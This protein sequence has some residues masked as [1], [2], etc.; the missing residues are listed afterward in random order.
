[1]EEF[2]FAKAVKEIYGTPN[3]RGVLDSLKDSQ[4]MSS[5][6]GKTPLHTGYLLGRKELILELFDIINTKDE[7]E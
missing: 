4:C 7:D 1:M 2:D 3:G 6:L 5:A